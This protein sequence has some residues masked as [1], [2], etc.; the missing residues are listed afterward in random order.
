MAICTKYFLFMVGRLNFLCGEPCGIAFHLFLRSSGLVPYSF[1]Y[2]P[3]NGN[4]RQAAYISFPFTGFGSAQK[5][6]IHFGLY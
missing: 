6:F 3:K 2:R 5:G 4:N 1:K